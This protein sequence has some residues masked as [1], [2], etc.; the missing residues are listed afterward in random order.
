[1]MCASIP[2]KEILDTITVAEINTTMTNLTDM[3]PEMFSQTDAGRRLETDE[4][5]VEEQSVVS[6]HTSI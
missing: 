5:M 1:M 3:F 6:V 2:Q 4:K